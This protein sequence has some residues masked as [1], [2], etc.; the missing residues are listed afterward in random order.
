MLWRGSKKA[1]WRFVGKLAWSAVWKRLGGLWLFFNRPGV[2][3]IAVR[4][5][6]Q[7]EPRQATNSPARPLDE[8]AAHHLVSP[9]RGRSTNQPGDHPAIKS[10]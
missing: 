6:Q 5:E 1:N 4:G 7:I 8:H 10:G 3:S 9:P 2:S